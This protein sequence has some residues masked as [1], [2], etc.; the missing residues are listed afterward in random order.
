MDLFNGI[1]N[2]LS[3]VHDLSVL[4]ARPS[5]EDQSKSEFSVVLLDII[6]EVNGDIAKYRAEAHPLDPNR[7]KLHFSSK[8]LKAIATQVERRLM[9]R[10]EEESIAFGAAS[11]QVAAKNVETKNFFASQLSTDFVWRE[12]PDDGD[13]F[14]H[15]AVAQLL[16]NENR[17]VLGLRGA[18]ADY[19][20][21]KREDFEPYM[22]ESEDFDLHI[23]NLRESSRGKAGGIGQ[24][25]NIHLRAMS[26][27]L[28]RPVHAYRADDSD[29]GKERDDQQRPLPGV[30]F[31]DELKGE[32]IRL[33]YNGVNHWLYIEPKGLGKKN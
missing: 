23:K 1:S 3:L 17:D 24:G 31:G 32:P 10:A 4:L 29:F 13:C 18:I 15:A 26:E 5:G 7:I 28:G 33:L 16:P 21:K 22:D 11:E 14:F 12:V 30:R 20:V 25:D 9:S 27:L 19:M 8:E 6:R 2:N